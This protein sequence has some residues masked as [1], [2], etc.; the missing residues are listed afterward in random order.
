MAKEKNQ[1]KKQIFV[2]EAV[3]KI[4][5]SAGFI[6]TDYQGLTVEQV[7]KLRRELEKVGAI[8]KVTKNTVSKRA[9]DAMN[10]NGDVK[11][12][13][14]GVTGVVFSNDYVSAAKVLANFAKENEKLQIK[15]G[16]IESKRYTM[17]EIKEISKLSSKEEL[18]A[19]LV[20]LL[21]QPIVKFVRQIAKPTQDVVYALNAVKEKKA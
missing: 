10:I 16:F 13:F 3:S 18:I 4:R 21:N 11:K 7:N 2:D 20:Y 19:K 14:K 17:D 5:E 1:A 8:Y 9:L 15:G 6:I 12:M